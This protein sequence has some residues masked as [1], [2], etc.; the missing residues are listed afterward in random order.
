MKLFCKGY[1]LTEL[2][3][4]MAIMTILSVIA[5]PTYTNYLLKSRRSDGESS[6][7]DLANR[8]ERYFI[9]NNTYEGATL[10]NL[11]LTGTTESGYYHLTL[12][13]LGSNTYLLQAEP[14]GPQ[15][16]DTLCGVLTLNS[17][18]EKGIKG[19]GEIS[20]CW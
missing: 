10:S 2:I 5:Y 14:V 18:G 1:T 7:L 8:M 11:G 3:I 20:D 13:D 19:S 6:L 9:I 17:L 4:A 16:A 15:A 12:G